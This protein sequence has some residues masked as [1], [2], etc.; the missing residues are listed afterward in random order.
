MLLTLDNLAHRYHCLPSEALDRATTFDLKV[1]DAS[2]KYS[3]HQHEL[4]NER[5]TGKKPIPKLSTEQM[6]N[7]I[8]EAR[9][10][11]A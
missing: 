5:E 4:A 1:L 11:K 6:L 10:E 7:M 2:A 3:N 9:G 8:K